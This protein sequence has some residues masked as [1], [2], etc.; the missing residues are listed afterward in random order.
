MNNLKYTLLLIILTCLFV[1]SGFAQS[2]KAISRRI[3]THLAQFHADYSVALVQERPEM[4]VSYY[5]DSIRLMPEFQKTVVRKGNA[6][7]YHQAFLA[8]YDVQEYGKEATEVLDM[9]SQLAEIGQFFMKVAMKSTGHEYKLNGK[10]INIWNKSPKGELSLLTEAWNYDHSL[11]IEKQ[12][13]FKKV[14]PARLS[15]E[16][17]VPGSKPVY[18]EL[19]ALSSFM[20][21]IVSQ[22]NA[23]QWSQFY[24][25]D[26]SFLYSR[27]PMYHG[28]EA[29]DGFFEEHVRELP[30]FE[31]LK[32]YHDRIDDLGQ[33]VIVYSN[34][35][36][37]VNG[38]GFSG[39][40]TG[41][42]LAIWRR[43]PNCSLK[44]F[45]HIAMYD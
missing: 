11:A 21:A 25:D 13:K 24:A 12:L 43:E 38:D 44:I 31:Q 19:A 29:L 37:D 4:I 40:F 35:V 26:A 17:R 3:A 32:I 8:R 1:T 5:S 6:R 7:L 18:F 10:Y 20:E 41:K 16:I 33:Y 34:H 23:H 30:A 42:D 9:D 28:R 15:S 22:H 39:T 27:H 45:H 14:P 36:A 2:A